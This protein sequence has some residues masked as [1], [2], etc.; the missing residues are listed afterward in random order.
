MFRQTDRA[1]LEF[2][3]FDV[4]YGMQRGEVRMSRMT[5]SPMMIP[6]RLPLCDQTRNRSCCCTTV[7]ASS[8][9]YY[10]TAMDSANQIGLT[11]QGVPVQ[12]AI[13][14]DFSR[15]A[16]VVLA[17]LQHIDAALEHRLSDVCSA[18]WRG[19]SFCSDREVQWCAAFRSPDKSLQKTREC[20]AQRW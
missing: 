16:F 6:F 14:S 10:Q 7:I 9:F 19:C 8:A 4:P 1:Q 5:R 11:L 3:S 12:Q 17:D 2:L 18:R 20:K 13:D 15:F